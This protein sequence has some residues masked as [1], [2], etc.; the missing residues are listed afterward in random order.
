MIREAVA[1]DIPRI[2]EMGREFHALSPWRAVPFDPEAVAAFAARLIEGGVILISD[3]GMLGGVLSPLYFN[4]AHA[5]AVE[6]FWW[7][8]GGGGALR[9]AFEAWASERG[10][11]AGQMGVLGNEHAE[12]MGQMLQRHGYRL[13]ESG[14]MKELA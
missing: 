7:A 8:K 4:P 11:W 14:Y 10:A 5:I 6:M 9:E 12:A 2:V 1:G 3:T 13:V